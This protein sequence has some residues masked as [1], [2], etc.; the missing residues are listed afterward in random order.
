MN[1]MKRESRRRWAVLLV[2]VLILGCFGYSGGVQAVN[3]EE[4]G[5]EEI[6]Y[7]ESIQLADGDSS[8][9]I[10]MEKEQESSKY[11]GDVNIKVVTTG[12]AV[13]A[14]SLSG[15]AW[16]CSS[17]L[18]S[19]NFVFSNQNEERQ[20]GTV[21]SGS[22]VSGTSEGKETESVPVGS[23]VTGS[24]I[25]VDNK[26]NDND[27]IKISEV[28]QVNEE[29]QLTVQSATPFNTKNVF[30]WYQDQQGNVKY[31]YCVGILN[32]SCKCKVTYDLND[33]S[34]QDTEQDNTQKVTYGETIT[35]P[36][37]D[38]TRI[39]HIFKEWY[40]DKDYKTQ[41][42][43][44]NFVTDDITLYAKWES[45]PTPSSESA[46]SASPTATATATVT[47]T[48]SPSLTP[49]P[50]VAP[51]QTS[52]ATPTNETE[53]TEP[54]SSAPPT[55]TPPTDAP[56]SQNPTSALPAS[57][58]P[59]SQ[60]SAIP[61]AVTPATH[62]VTFMDGDVELKKV[63]VVSGCA[64][65][66]GD[67][68]ANPQKEG[69]TF[70]GWYTDPECKEG[71]EFKPDTPISNNI[72]VYAKWNLITKPTLIPTNQPTMLPNPVVQSP[73]PT[74]PPAGEPPQLQAY[75]AKR[76]IVAKGKEKAKLS[77]IVNGSENNPGYTY[78]WYMEGQTEPLGEG[79]QFE[80][81][82]KE[83]KTY[84]LFCR[85]KDAGGNEYDSNQVLV[86]CYANNVG[87]T[88][89][90][91]ITTKQIFGEKEKVNK[92]SLVNTKKFKAKK[93]F[94]VKKSKGKIKAKKYTG[95]KAKVKIVTTTGEKIQI[96]VFVKS[97]LPAPG[98]KIIKSNPNVPG[99][100][101]RITFRYSNNSSATKMRV[102]FVGK[103]SS[104]MKKFF[105]KYL[106]GKK[107]GY[108][109]STKRHATYKFRIWAIYGK[110]KST[111]AKKPVKW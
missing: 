61:P 32:L 42:D 94:S 89:Y 62:T 19:N 51:T 69:Y 7:I 80:F 18:A 101:K 5:S 34:W 4:G 95:K 97:P 100:T 47:P 63:S 27:E 49:A 107:K 26:I 20:D 17:T 81:P 90:K 72:T 65:N 84:K 57:E 92:M 43:F 1:T 96:K 24:S 76:Y 37:P 41:Y 91:S 108:L 21:V 98:V 31:V 35:K 28:R 88:L 79:Q 104:S 50:T 53:T 111:A 55:D 46:T 58:P 52:S 67:Y 109:D 64:V 78:T 13:S 22:S 6:E 12:S 10:D 99:Y 11:S 85:V 106:S 73:A 70:G 54:A 8:K 15:I 33:G 102:R 14:A 75:A 68:P 86:T 25:E 9:T 103:T 38:P 56:A 82:S 2:F 44:K 105:D 40:G 74:N 39:G 110:K 30:L 60:P 29:Y 3:S 83:K 16:N 36:S 71:T 93:Y 45:N 23:V 77:V 59:S 66:A 87:I 48:L